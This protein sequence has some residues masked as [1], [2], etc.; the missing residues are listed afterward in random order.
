VRSTSERA[1]FY[2]AH[3]AYFIPLDAHL[4]FRIL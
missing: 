3:A 2:H 4:S 1:S